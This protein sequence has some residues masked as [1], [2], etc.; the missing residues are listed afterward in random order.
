MTTRKVR[1]ELIATDPSTF[2]QSK[3]RPNR[4]FAP[5]ATEQDFVD[6]IK[7][8][9]NLSDDDI[10][11]IKAKATGSLSSRFP[12]FRFKVGTNNISIVLAKGIQRGERGELTQATNLQEQLAQALHING[13]SIKIKIGTLEPIEITSGLVRKVSGNPL[14]DLSIDDLIFIQ[15]K[16]ERF[17]QLSG[18]IKTSKYVNGP[19]LTEIDNFVKAVSTTSG[20]AL[21]PTQNYK[22]IV[23]SLSLA[24]IALFGGTESAPFNIDHIQ[25]ICKG[26]LRLVPI[27]ESAGVYTIQ[28][29]SDSSSL[30]VTDTLVPGKG[31][32]P[33][34]FAKY[35]KEH[36]QKGI[37]HCRFNFG[38]SNFIPNAI[39]I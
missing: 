19:D 18:L 32:W 10:D 37:V 11:I 15:I 33:Y 31:W 24:K 16:E 38:A 34:M 20:G 39:D 12:T 35:S 1:D 4:I 7:S 3:T 9:Y 8:K 27:D 21:R 28:G 23:E 14:A 30:S 25:L 26:N 36:S 6:A 29:S 2:R 5:N 17:Q 22:R 13:G